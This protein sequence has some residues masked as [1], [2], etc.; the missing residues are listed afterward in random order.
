MLLILF[1]K[2]GSGKNYIGRILKK[3]FGFFFFDG[4]TS[5]TLAM[6]KKIKKGAVISKTMRRHFYNRLVKK[7]GKLIKL[8]KKIVMAQSMPIEKYRRLILK[9]FPD[10]RFFLVSADLAAMKRRLRK[11]K[12][13]ADQ[14]YC[15]KIHQLFEKPGIK[16]K[17]IFNNTAGKKGL[18]RRVQ[19][20]LAGLEN[21]ANNSRHGQRA[22]PDKQDDGS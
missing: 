22:A 14:N 13:L 19:R 5:L 17:I 20:M 6:R 10:A 12:H 4:D 2:P 21:G 3:E 7:I 18:T 1:G 8:R 11:R 16:H 15:E 9:K